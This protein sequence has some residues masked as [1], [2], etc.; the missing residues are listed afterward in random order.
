MRIG[1]V[2][3]RTGVSARM[4]R[5]YEQQ[6]LLDPGRHPNGYR[7][8]TAEDLH[9]VT[10]IRDLSGA[11]VPTRFIRIVLDKQSG[12]VAW[13]TTCDEILAGLVRDQVAALD[14]KITC[15]STSREALTHFL[16][17]SGPTPTARIDGASTPG[18]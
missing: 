16:L 12:E 13:T 5:Y 9:R 8:Y 15:L 2:T 17:E 18:S 6:G 14:A 10:T 1:E 11:G 4:L 7:D 3:R